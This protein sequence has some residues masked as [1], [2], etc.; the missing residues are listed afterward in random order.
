MYPL[1]DN[2][3]QTL[4]LID[5]LITERM[6]KITI[7]AKKTPGYIAT[8]DSPEYSLLLEFK[9]QVLTALRIVRDNEKITSN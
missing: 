1:T 4:Q 2:N 9:V 7:N 6:A 5:G 8:L 3:K